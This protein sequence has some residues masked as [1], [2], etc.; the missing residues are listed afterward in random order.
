M[1][2]RIGIWVAFSF[3]LF[4]L[5]SYAQPTGNEDRW[6][7][8]NTMVKIANPV[9]DNLSQGTLKKNM[10]FESLSTEPFRREVSY[11]EYPVHRN[12]NTVLCLKAS[13]D[14]S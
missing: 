5:K 9:L 12:P 3:L 1:K 6:Y 2:N 4:C 10:P 7:W 8:V 14:D 11:L 13:W